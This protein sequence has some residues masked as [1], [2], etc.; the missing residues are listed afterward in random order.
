MF[1]LESLAIA[2]LILFSI[3]FL[4]KL[5]AYADKKS[6]ASFYLRHRILRTNSPR[7]IE[8]Y[9]IEFDSVLDKQTKDALL[10]RKDELITDQILGENK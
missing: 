10:R 8:N 3:V 6:D 5:I 7:E 1:I 4:A 2:C 9:L